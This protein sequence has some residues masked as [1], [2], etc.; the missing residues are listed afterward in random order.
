MM[1]VQNCLITGFVREYLRRNLIHRPNRKPELLC[2]GRPA[3]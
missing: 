2:V 3:H 1:L